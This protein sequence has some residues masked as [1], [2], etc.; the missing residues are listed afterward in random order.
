MQRWLRDATLRPDPRFAD[1][2][3]RRLG[4]AAWDLL[5]PRSRFFLATALADFAGRGESPVSDY[6]PVNLSL[7]KALEVELGRI[8]EGFRASRSEWPAAGHGRNDQLLARYLATP[9]AAAPTIGE[10]RHLFAAPTGPLHQALRD[11]IEST[12]HRAVTTSRFREKLAKVVN[13]YR[14]GGVHDKPIPL[15]TCRACFADLLDGE[16]RPGLVAIAAGAGAS[17]A[18]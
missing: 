13:V 9:D 12:E 10:I 14:N 5:D 7:I 18:E 11:H 1:E 3:R 17:R 8:L 2:A 6:A 15:D 16:T 4:V